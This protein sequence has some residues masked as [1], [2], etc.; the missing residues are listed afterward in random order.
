LSPVIASIAAMIAAF[1]SVSAREWTHDGAMSGQQ[2]ARH[3]FG[4]R[5]DEPLD[6]GPG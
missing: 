2:Q 5:I 4:R 3:Q 6:F 1:S